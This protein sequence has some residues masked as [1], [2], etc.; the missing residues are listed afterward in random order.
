M[1]LPRK[2]TNKSLPRPLPLK[3]KGSPRL[4]VVSLINSSQLHSAPE[5]KRCTRPLH[6][7][8]EKLKHIRSYSS[9]NDSSSLSSSSSSS[10]ASLG[11]RNVIF[12]SVTKFLIL[13]LKVR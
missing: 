2:H 5:V 10:S 12:Q 7:D 9:A 4:P 8:I 13:Y 11:R 3:N 1:I 6:I